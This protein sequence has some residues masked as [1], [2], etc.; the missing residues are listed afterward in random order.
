[1]DHLDEQVK[2]S[3]ESSVGHIRFSRREEVRAELHGNGS[4]HRVRRVLHRMRKPVLAYAAV[5]LVALAISLGWLLREPG[6]P[7]GIQE[8]VIAAGQVPFA[9]VQHLM[10]Q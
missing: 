8:Q 10:G 4:P 6:Q 1:M 3:L 2:Q 7:A 9:A 5:M